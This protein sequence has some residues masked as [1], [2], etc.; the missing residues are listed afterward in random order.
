[1]GI[2]GQTAC[3]MA[4]RVVGDVN[5]GGGD[6]V[7]KGEGMKGMRVLVN[8]ASGGVGSVLVQICKGM[9]AEVVVGVCSG[10]S[11]GLVKGL[12]VDEVVDYRVHNPLEDHLAETFGEQ[13]FDAVLDCVGSQALYTHSPRYLKPEG[14][15]INIVGGWSQGVVPFIRNKLRP[16]L[17]GG[18]PRGYE[19]F[20]LSASGETAR[21]AAAFVEQGIIKQAVIDSVF[22]MEEAIEAYERLA[23]GRAKGKVVVE[24]DNS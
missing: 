5:G 6:G 10:A 19:L 15:F 4:R 23:T 21:E 22:P 2:A 24:V 1:M 14:K 18:T 7:G 8:G 9:G 16:C 12:G 17:L 11:E 20:L 13:H 3:A